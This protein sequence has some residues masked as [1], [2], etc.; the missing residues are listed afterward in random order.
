MLLITGASGL[1]GGNMALLAGQQ[2]K[3]VL[4]LYHG[5][6]LVMPEAVSVRLDLEDEDGL[7]RLFREHPIQSVIHC[8]AMTNVD[9]CESHHAEAERIN[10]VVPGRLATLAREAGA[11]MLHVSTDQVFDGQRGSYTEESPTAP[12]NVYGRTKLEGEQSVLSELPSALVIRTNMYGWNTTE[13]YSLGEWVLSSLEAGKSI[14][15]FRD[16]VFTPL[17]VND[18]CGL[19]LKMLRQGLEGIWHLGGSEAISKYAFARKLAKV[20]GLDADLVWA[21]SIDDVGLAAPRPLDMSLRS[22]KAARRLE[23]A[24]PDVKSGLERFQSLR[25]EGYVKTLKSLATGGSGA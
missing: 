17:L 20:F 2:G 12:I 14:P 22:D 11:Q 21:A 23:V 25:D 19:M 10:A 4:A 16:V 5:N 18:L 24:L 1:L 15:G 3:K 9:Y 13:K 6:P 7:Q 8:A